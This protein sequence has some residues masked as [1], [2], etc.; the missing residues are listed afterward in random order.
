MNRVYL[1]LRHNKE[2]G[3]Y[4]LEELIALSPKPFDLIWL[5]GKSSGWSYPTDIEELKT[6]MA[7]IN[8][9]IQQPIS[10]INTTSYIPS[11]ENEN[12]S[13]KITPPKIYVSLPNKVV[14]QHE[15]VQDADPA[16][17]LEKKAKELRKKVQEYT[18]KSSPHDNKLQTKF[19]R[20]PEPVE[21]DNAS[22][23][24]QK[25][26]KKKSFSKK[27]LF[28][29][30]LS[31]VLL[32]GSYFLVQ[33]FFNAE[34]HVVQQVKV[35]PFYQQ[36]TT[37]VL[38]AETGNLETIES[39]TSEKPS[40]SMVKQTNSSAK[41]QEKKDAVLLIESPVNPSLSKESV[42]QKNE[43]IQPDE[44]PNNTTISQEKVIQETVVDTPKEKKKTLAEKIDKFFDKLGSKK[45]EGPVSEDQPKTST[46]GGERK[47]TRRDDETKTPV[48][49]VDLASLVDITANNP[50]NWMMGVK[51]LKLTLRN[52]SN[53]IIKTASVEVRYYTE[54]NSLLEKKLVYFINVAPKKSL[55]VDAPDQRLADHADF[56]LL[57]VSNK[58]DSYVKQ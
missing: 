52:R 8:K 44:I 25:V 57:S 46:G 42:D 5:E 51:G 1:L 3:P 32:T 30:A 34:A 9:A 33:L 18:A 27:N 47:S 2:S 23:I 16:Y 36:D 50:D 55:P 19:T 28:I 53:E 22:W 29:P 56:R 12:P 37:K 4:S 45:Q 40:P 49:E 35:Q 48:E 54:Q 26:Q 15:P 7:D 38:T 41:M 6:Y 14:Q 10:T 24:Y 43:S 17:S 20:P 39:T 13:K 58:D 11:L 31:L 21:Q